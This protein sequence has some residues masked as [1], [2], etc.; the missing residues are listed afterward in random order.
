MADVTKEECLKEFKRLA[1]I[2]GRPPKQKEFL[3]EAHISSYYIGK[4]FGENAFAKIMSTAGFQ[5]RQTVKDIPKI[6]IEKFWDSYAEMLRKCKHVPSTAEWDNNHFRPVHSSF[7]AKLNCK[8]SEIPILFKKFTKD[9]PEYADVLCYLPNPQ[10][11]ETTSFPVLT[12][13]D[14]FYPFV[15]PILQN[16]EEIENSTLFEE[17]VSVCFQLLGFKNNHLGQGQGQNPDGIA[18]RP[19]DGYAIIYDAKAHLDGY[20]IVSSDRRAAEQYIEDHRGKLE[21]TG[22]KTLF[23][24]FVARS[25]NS[26]CKK[27]IQG[28]REKTNVTAV[29]IT[30]S[31]LLYLVVTHIQN[32]YDFDHAKLKALLSKGGQ[33]DR[34]TIQSFLEEIHQQGST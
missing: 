9:K 27:A 6:S 17:K 22:S 21:K 34:E 1:Q 5:P 4:L 33:I 7:R 29:L 14:E 20:S 12:Q 23:F 15:P 3:K 32:P 28:I 11:N 25:F 13:K 16:F 26:D 2:K 10:E 8:F 19:K 31:A 24:A 30:A 18:S